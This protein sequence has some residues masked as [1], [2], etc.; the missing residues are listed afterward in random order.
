MTTNPR[1]NLITPIEL[2]EPTA[3]ESQIPPRTQQEWACFKKITPRRQWRII[4]SKE[5]KPSSRVNSTTQLSQSNWWTRVWR[6][7]LGRQHTRALNH[8]ADATLPWIQIVQIHPRTPIT[9]C[10]TGTESSLKP[11]SMNQQRDRC[12]IRPKSKGTRVRWT[13]LTS[14]SGIRAAT[15]P[16]QIMESRRWRRSR[17]WWHRSAP[18]TRQ[19]FTRVAMAFQCMLINK[20]V[21]HRASHSSQCSRHIWGINSRTP[22]VTYQQSW[23]HPNLSCRVMPPTMDKLELQEG[24]RSKVAR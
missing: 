24:P 17:P 9:L 23:S 5:G 4:T 12:R 18:H 21:C 7:W 15:Q 6:M 14:L 22:R 10:D 19:T 1:L 11:A 2:V 16:I 20:T 3:L 13:R 8:C